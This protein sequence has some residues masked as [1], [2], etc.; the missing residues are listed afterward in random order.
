MNV[1]ERLLGIMNP[2]LQPALM[3]RVSHDGSE[4]RVPNATSQIRL[5]LPKTQQSSATEASVPVPAPA[6][7]KQGAPA[8]AQTQQAVP[9]VTAVTGA[10]AGTPFAQGTTLDDGQVLGALNLQ[11]DNIVFAVFFIPNTIENPVDG[12]WEDIDVPKPEPLD[13]QQ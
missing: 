5:I 2:Q 1:K 6:T 3:A 8:A 4:Y 12:K 10:P 9:V 13:E 11:M 7:G